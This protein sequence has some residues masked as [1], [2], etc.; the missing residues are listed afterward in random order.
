MEQIGLGTL[1][2]I[3]KPVGV[4]DGDVVGAEVF[5]A[6]VPV[7]NGSQ[8]REIAIEVN[9]LGVGPTAGPTIHQVTLKG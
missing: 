2:Y 6:P 9:V 1:P 3:A 8:V 5:A 7:E 4:R